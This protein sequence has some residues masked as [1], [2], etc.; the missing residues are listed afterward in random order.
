MWLGPCIRLS[1]IGNGRT[2]AGISGGQWQFWGHRARCP[3]WD[4]GGGGSEGRPASTSSSP[5]PVATSSPS[6]TGAWPPGS[7][8]RHPPRADRRVR[9]RGV[10]QGHPPARRGRPHRRS[11]RDQRDERHHQCVLLWVSD[12]GHRRAGPR[13][14]LGVRLAPGGRP[15]ADRGRGDQ[16]GGDRGQDRRHLARGRRLP[17]RRRRRRPGGRASSTSR[18][19]S[20]STGPGPAE[21]RVVAATSGAGSGGPA[22]PI[23]TRWPRWRSSWPTPSGR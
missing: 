18:S 6:T 1:L 22:S 10:G 14:P 19:T 11:R 9:R 8:G 2:T 21:P 13:R 5:C 12:G 16:A 23:P 17:R 3:R 15:R 7:A 4:A 20:S